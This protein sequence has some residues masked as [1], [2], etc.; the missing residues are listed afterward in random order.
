[1]SS[2]KKEE[3]KACVKLKVNRASGTY[4]QGEEVEGKILVTGIKRKL[5][6]LTLQVTGAYVPSH[7]PKALE[8]CPILG[9]IGKSVIF[10]YNLS[11]V[12]DLVVSGSIKKSFKF[13]LDRAGDN[14]SFYETYYGFLFAIKV[15]RINS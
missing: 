11:L 2:K 9:K 13:T 5:N 4:S 14:K 7:A 12:T 15:G 1:M 6:F 8:A 3:Q 10:E